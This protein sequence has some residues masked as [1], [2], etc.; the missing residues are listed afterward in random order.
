MEMRDDWDGTATGAAEDVQGCSLDETAKTVARHY[1]VT[2][3]GALN[4]STSSATV[5]R[6]LF[7]TWRRLPVERAWSSANADQST[8]RNA[9]GE[10]FTWKVV[11]PA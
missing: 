2:L 5:M 10:R 8:T 6:A 3:K 11:V 4:A 7:G 1:Q 9:S